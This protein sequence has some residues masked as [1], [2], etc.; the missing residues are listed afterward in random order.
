MVLRGG[1]E[2]RG[3]RSGMVFGCADGMR[4]VWCN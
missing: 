3:E 1:F 2:L 4:E